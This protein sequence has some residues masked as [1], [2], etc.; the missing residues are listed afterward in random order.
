MCPL[1][2]PFQRCQL[3]CLWSRLQGVVPQAD[4]EG[5]SHM[6]PAQDLDL[7]WYATAIYSLSHQ[8]ISWN[9]FTPLDKSLIF[10]PYIY[11]YI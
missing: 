10:K 6:L 8:E 9:P 4:R 3:S 11:I 7:S 5:K 1:G 2:L